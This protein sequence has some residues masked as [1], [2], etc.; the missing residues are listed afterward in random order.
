MRNANFYWKKLG[1]DDNKKQVPQKLFPKRSLS[2]INEQHNTHTFFMVSS[3]KNIVIIVD[4]VHIFKA[5]ACYFLFFHQMI[6][7]QKL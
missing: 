2:M 3:S 7:L 5:Y 6:A 1:D 4:A